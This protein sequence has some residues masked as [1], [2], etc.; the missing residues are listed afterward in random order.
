M[1][2]GRYPSLLL[3]FHDLLVAK[4]FASLPYGAAEAGGTLMYRL[5][6]VRK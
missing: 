4:S 2:I 6:N 1:H 5:A 3:P